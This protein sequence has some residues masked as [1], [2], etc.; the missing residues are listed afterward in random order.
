MKPKPYLMALPLALMASACSSLDEPTDGHQGEDI[1]VTI[2]AVTD[3]TPPQSRAGTEDIS[4][5]TPTRYILEYTD[6]HGAV[7]RATSDD[8]SF[9][10][11]LKYGEKYSCLFW[12]DNGKGYD[13]SDLTAVTITAQPDMAA[14][15]GST[16]I[17]AGVSANEAY[18]ITLVHAV[19]RVDLIQKTHFAQTPTLLNVSVNKSFSLDVAS[20]ATQLL[21][22]NVAYELSGIKKESAG[23]CIGTAYFIASQNEAA[24]TTMT[25]SMEGEGTSNEMTSVP[26]RRNYVTKI[27]GNFSD[28]HNSDIDVSIDENWNSTYNVELWDGVS[29]SVPKDY[30]NGDKSFYITNPRELAWLAQESAKEGMTFED[31]DIYIDR[32][33]YLNNMEW[34]PIGLNSQGFKGKIYGQGYRIN[35]LKISSKRYGNIGLFAS[36]TKGCK[37]RYLEVYGEVTLDSP[38]EETN[39]G[40]IIGKMSD[41]DLFYLHSYVTINVTN[42]KSGNVGG[43]TGNAI[44]CDLSSLYT[45]N[46]TNVDGS[47]MNVGGTVGQY[48]AKNFNISGSSL[49]FGAN[50]ES[51]TISVSGGQYNNVGGLVGFLRGDNR[52]DVNIQ[53]CNNKASVEIINS[54]G[55]ICGGLIGGCNGYT[56]SKLEIWGCENSF[57][58]TVSQSSDSFFGEIVGQA[59]V[60]GGYTLK[61]TQPRI[62]GNVVVRKCYISDESS[63]IIYNSNP[64]TGSNGTSIYK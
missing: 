31:Y 5:T 15:C 25:F 3:N 43:I 22:E 37:I 48:T 64:F 2:T 40:G 41:S 23:K 63:Q 47:R 27:T 26:L 6:E 17:Q 44:D 49:L 58:P 52:N 20:G 4:E 61:L 10:L 45:Y 53:N 9:N 60:S 34:T 56:T 7:N 14:Y 35:G 29:T 46:D 57:I 55:S 28:L 32:D 50:H 59:Q 12:A 21:A 13:A 42:G 38:D 33:I 62:T 54:S 36:V 30:A 24:L 11:E 18:T 39:I 16:E 51:G 8:G 1:I 19:A